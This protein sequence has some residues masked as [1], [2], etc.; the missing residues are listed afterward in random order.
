MEVTPLK[1]FYT[2][3]SHLSEHFPP[4]PARPQPAHYILKEV[5]VRRFFSYHAWN[6]WPMKFIFTTGIIKC[7]GNYENLVDT[8]T[9]RNVS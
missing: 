1:E 4:G 7:S 2:P 8:G 6:L 9:V 3:W 5:P